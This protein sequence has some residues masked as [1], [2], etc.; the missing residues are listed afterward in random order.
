[1][2]IYDIYLHTVLPGCFKY[3]SFSIL[4]GRIATLFFWP[5]KV[6]KLLLSQ[7]RRC[8]RRWLRQDVDDMGILW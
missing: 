1:M 2:Y 5:R 6:A 7:L 3:W 4:P 8:L